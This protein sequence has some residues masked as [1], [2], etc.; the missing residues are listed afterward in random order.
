[1]TVKP[2]RRSWPYILPPLLLAL[3][4]AW[5]GRTYL[6]RDFHFAADNGSMLFTFTEGYWAR[7]IGAT[8]Y[9]SSW[10]SMWAE[11][12]KYAETHFKVAGLEYVAGNGT[13]NMPTSRYAM[14]RVPFFYPILLLAAASALSIATVRRRSR[15]G[16]HACPRCGYDCRATPDRCPE[17]GASPHPDAGA[18]PP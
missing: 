13:R 15:A 2:T 11:A 12:L 6:P 16:P 5:W 8:E 1:M 10:Q 9:H 17:C 3:A 14:L 18:G 4:L 7:R